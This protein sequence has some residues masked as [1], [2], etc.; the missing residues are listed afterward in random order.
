MTDQRDS[1]H[2]RTDEVGIGRGP[3]NYVRRDDGSWSPVALVLG[4]LLLLLFGYM[5]FADRPG[6]AQPSTTGMSES[7]TNAGGTTRQPSGPQK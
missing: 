2:R 4:A 1:E 3:R 7:P 6:P 5:L